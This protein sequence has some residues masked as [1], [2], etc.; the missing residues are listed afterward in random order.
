MIGQTIAHYQVSAKVGAGGMGEVY[1]ARDSKLDRDVALKLLPEAF[2]MD[3]ERLARFDR[4]AKLLAG[5]NHTHIAAIYGTEHSNGKHVLVLEYVEGED[6]AQ[7]LETGPIPVDESLAIAL[8]IADALEAAH[9]QGV[10]HR[11]LKPA[12]VKVTPDGHVKVLDFGLAKTLDSDTESDIANSP[13]LLASS[14]TVQGVIL[15]TAGYMSPEQARGK[16]VD[17][18]GDIFA[19]GCVLYEMLS[20]TRG[21][22]GDTISD[23]LASVLKEHPDLDKLPGDTPPAIRKLI[24]RCLDKD[25]R[26]RL[27]DIGEARILIDKVI[28][29]EVEDAPAA[30]KAAP[31]SRVK[32]IIP[33]AV[34]ALLVIAAI[35][36]TRQVM[37]SSMPQPPL[38]KFRI[39]VV[40]HGDAPAE[41]V[42]SP[43]GSKVAYV[44]GG[45][46]VV[47]PLDDLNSITIVTGGGAPRFPFWSPDGTQIGYF[48]EGKIWRVPAT[49]GATVLVCDPAVGFTGGTGGT[50]TE[51][52]RIIFGTGGSGL[53]EVPVQGGDEKVFLDVGPDEGDHHE[54]CALPGDRGIL[55]LPHPSASQPD[56]IE[57]YANGERR[58]LLEIAGQ[59]LHR[60][61]YSPTGH[62]VFRRPGANG[63]IWALP[64]SLSKLAA[65]GE[66][67]IV[68]AG[69]GHGSVGADGTLVY[70]MGANVNAFV[71]RWL[72]R[73]GT[74]SEPIS[75]PG[76]GRGFPNFSPDGKRAVV[77]EYN[78]ENPDLWIYDIARQSRTRFTF[79]SGLDIYPAWGPD[80]K[81]IYYW[82][83]GPDSV[84]RKAA[85]GTGVR[86]PVIDGGMPTVSPDMK[87]I[88]FKRSIKGRQD[89]IH[90]MDLETKE[91]V[92]LIATA[93]DEDAPLMSPAG[94][95]LA[96]DS[97]ESGEWNMYV[98]PFPS[99]SGKWQVSLGD[100]A[101][102]TWGADGKSLHYST[103]GGDIMEVRFREGPSGLELSTPELL[104]NSNELNLPTVSYPYFKQSPAD[105]EKFL[106]MSPLASDRREVNTNLTVVQ[107]WVREFG[108]R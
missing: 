34:A 77:T 84:Y 3:E 54:P 50:W 31:A 10:I 60:P 94:G 45:D 25:P 8:Q 29:G 78:D 101:Y 57:V 76:P 64:F 67:F 69:S 104:F 13:T 19:F 62:I 46:L 86:E 93:A 83:A 35:L 42:V 30:P 52:G 49:G 47:Q 48:A 98:T 41:P 38:R 82:S 107:H 68:S 72:H 90:Y 65:T 32:T 102:G 105:L 37:Q 20:G 66:P 92:A 9:D 53:L 16:R 2:A 85:D 81:D 27:R 6:L 99:G 89:D 70:L 63:G 4:E 1:R 79:E 71:M 108:G 95:Y 91:T 12:N 11:D 33:Y 23:T 55:F 21:F 5:L 58:V 80:G 24:D 106:I 18:R 17:R 100:Y 39:P 44:L 88:V 73:D 7:R 26:Q 36:T 51:D 75:E 74:V 56:R 96:Y 28:R 103:N 61:R 15:G 97:N 87:Y 43:D 40:S 59:R 22:T 14:P